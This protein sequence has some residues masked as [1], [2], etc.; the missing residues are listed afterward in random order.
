ML[1][2]RI[3]HVR[4]RG[5]DIPAPP[6][7]PPRPRSRTVRSNFGPRLPRNNPPAHGV[8]HGGGCPRTGSPHRAESAPAAAA[9]PPYVKSGPVCP[10]ERPGALGVAVLRQVAPGLA[11][12]PH[13]RVSRSSGATARAAGLAVEREE[14]NHGFF[15]ST[16]CPHGCPPKTWRIFA[17]SRAGVSLRPLGGEPIIRARLITGP[18][19]PGPP[20]PARSSPSPESD[21]CGRSPSAPQDP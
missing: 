18:A 9:S 17:S 15:S 4:K 10:S 14:G 1:G 8:G 2:D 6:V 5:A 21:T 16:A 12:Q 7:S 13:R 3:G 11:H 20:P 19:R